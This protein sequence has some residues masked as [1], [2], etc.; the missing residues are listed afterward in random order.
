M[1]IYSFPSSCICLSFSVCLSISLIIYLPF[2]PSVCPSVSPSACLSVHPSVCQYVF[3]SINL[4]VC[5]SDSVS[6]SICNLPAFLS[7][8]QSVCLSVFSLSL[9]LFLFKVLSF[10]LRC[11]VFQL[12]TPPQANKRTKV[13]LKLKEEGDK[14]RKKGKKKERKRGKN[15][16]LFHLPRNIFVTEAKMILL[17]IFSIKTIEKYFFE[18]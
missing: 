18:S 8:R 17:R 7:V 5:M 15:R 12:T 11:Y 3:P 13:F 14:E 6:P 10:F 1:L 9:S 4:F 16:S 2:C